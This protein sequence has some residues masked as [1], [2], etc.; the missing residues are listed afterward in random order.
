MEDQRQTQPRD[1]TSGEHSSGYAPPT[2][3]DIDTAHGP[4]VT[5][6]VS[7]STVNVSAPRSL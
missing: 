7:S 4:A 2:V 1:P 6:A 3:E 5:A